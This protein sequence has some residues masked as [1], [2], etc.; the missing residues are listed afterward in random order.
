M[1]EFRNVTTETLKHNES[2]SSFYQG[3]T[4]ILDKLVICSKA[5]TYS[6]RFLVITQVL[7]DP[8]NAA[9]PD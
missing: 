1:I 3:G 2:P 8:L 7:G 4:S 5:Q 9:Y 6:F